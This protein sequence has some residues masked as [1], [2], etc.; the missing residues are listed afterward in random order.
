MGCKERDLLF[1]KYA[2]LVSR[3]GETVMAVKTVSAT[4]ASIALLEESEMVRRECGQAWDL[5]QNHRREHGC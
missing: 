2:E 1:N 5:L 3:F 4:A